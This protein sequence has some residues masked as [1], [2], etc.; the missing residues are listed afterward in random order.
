MLPLLR[1]KECECAD[2]CS[3]DSAPINVSDQQHGSLGRL[4]HPHVDD[5]LIAKVD[6]GRAS[7]TLQN[8]QIEL[9]GQSRKSLLHRSAIL[10]GDATEVVGL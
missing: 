4:G 10:T 1:L 8:H 3:K 2:E 5:I 7:S 6:L 9:R